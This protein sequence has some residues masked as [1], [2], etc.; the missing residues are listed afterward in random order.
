M[1]TKI[2]A[3]L[4]VLLMVVITA[5]Q[6]QPVITATTE[7]VSP[8]ANDTATTTKEMQLGKPFIY[9]GNNLAHPTIKLMMLGF[10]DA[11]KDYEVDCKFIVDAG[12]DEASLISATEKAIAFGASGMDNSSYA[13]FR[14]E[15]LQVQKAGIPVVGQHGN[16]ASIDGAGSDV[17]GLIAWVAPDPILYGSQVADLVAE[18]TS[19]G[20][21]VI[22]T[23]SSFNS[24]E[25]AANKGFADEYLLKCPE[26]IILPTEQEGLE[27]VAAI[28][29]VSAV[30]L[31]NPDLVAAF[32]TTGG[33]IN[34]WGKAMQQAGYAPGKI[35]MIGM[36]ATQENIDMVRSGYAYALVNQPVYLENYR[37]VEILVENLRGEDFDYNNPIPSDIIT[38]DGLDSLEALAQ[39]SLTD[40]PNDN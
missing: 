23:Q 15:M 29:K 7:P 30:I 6:K 14:T 9:V 24:T 16:V 1:K 32:G 36:D 37:A 4:V 20:S 12:T 38:A 31:A 33:S 27:P 35:L 17:T 11:C 10:W 40:L 13:Q 5:C 22:V 18:K 34:T 28:A 26:A 25:D 3:I 19:C 39:R 8:T 2:F 21:P